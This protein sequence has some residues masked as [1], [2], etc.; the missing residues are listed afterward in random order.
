[1]KQLLLSLLAATAAAA[2]TAAPAGNQNQFRIDVQGE[3]EL[4]LVYRSGSEGTTGSQAGWLKEKKDTRLVVKGAIADEWKEFTFTFVPKADGRARLEIMSDDIKFF[5]AYD[6][7]RVTGATLANGD[8][9]TAG[10]QPDRPDRWW[11]MRKPVYVKDAQGASGKNFVL[12]AH[13]DRWIQSLPCKAGEAIT[14]TFLAKRAET[15]KSAE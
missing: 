1:M 7:F 2:V 13:N 8:F 9:E 4:G 12:C 3:K 14:V 6:N 5:V 10:K 15:P 11:P